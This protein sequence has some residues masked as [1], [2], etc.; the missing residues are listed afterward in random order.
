MA[1][2]RPKK[3]INEAQLGVICRL[4]PSAKDC[5]DFFEVSIDTIENKI[6]EFGYPSFSVFRE[7]NMVHTRFGLIQKAIDKGLKGDNCM[8]IFCLKN[9]CGWKDKWEVETINEKVNNEELIKNAMEA[10]EIL[11]EQK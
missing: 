5:A 1:G 10:I 9:L 3:E 11:K 8:L 6:H 4:K 2:G 7:Q